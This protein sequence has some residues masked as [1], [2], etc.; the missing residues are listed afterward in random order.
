LVKD[1][2]HILEVNEMLEHVALEE[3]WDIILKNCTAP[4]TEK[5]DLLNSVNRVLAEDIYAA[6]DLPPFDR[7]PLDGY[8]LRSIDTNDAQTT[9]PARLKIIA[10][11]AAGYMA[12]E[13]V[14]PGTAIKI[15]TG[16]PIPDGADAVIRFEDTVEDNG[17]VMIFAP[18][19]ENSNIVRA[20]EDVKQGEKLIERGTILSYGEIGIMAA[21]GKDKVTVYRKP[22][23]A[24]ISTGDELKDLGETL[25]HGK[26]YNSNLYTVGAAV[27]ESGG[28]P[29]LMGA[30]PDTIDGSMD[31]I[32]DAL[33]QA[34]IVLT[35]GGVSVGDYDVVKEVFKGIGAEL[36]FWRI[37]M[38]PG[39]PAVCARKGEK[40]LIGL[41][42]NPAAA[43]VT[44]ELIVRPLIY[45]LSGRKNYMLQKMTAVMEDD[46]TK[47]SCQRRF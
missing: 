47:K 12:A 33:A 41:S 44:Y 5:I 15:M 11:V 37:A 6:I 17:S 9:T 45:K 43:L 40:L 36:L 10:E 30:V 42:G 23:V 46:F 31:R 14:T 39:T 27:L 19:K 20:G 29:V 2:N 4:E 35:T 25:G 32:K 38:K 3:A 24:V 21:Q 13:K 26:I 8:A 18:L 28:I 22:K 34:D 1:V 7:S 16:A